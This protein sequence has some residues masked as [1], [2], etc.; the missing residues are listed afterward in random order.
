[1][2]LLLERAGR[3]VRTT[4]VCAGVAVAALCAG[5]FAAGGQGP[6]T[7]S[8]GVITAE[9]VTKGE[10]VYRRRCATCHLDDLVGADRYPPLVGDGFFDQW[11][12]GSL[13]DF[14][15][16]MRSMPAD[17]PASLTDAEYA[18]VAAFILKQNGVPTGA[19]PLPADPA[20]LKTITIQ[21]PR[22]P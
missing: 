21:K 17:A 2:R 19:S 22:R 14:L 11:I 13:S 4:G 20:V 7:T 18:D 9:Q 8:D 16:R 10:A 1:V 6:R 12:G 3:A 15:D 5:A